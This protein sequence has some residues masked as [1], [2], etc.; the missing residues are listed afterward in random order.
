LTNLAISD[1]D[2]GV[3]KKAILALSSGVRNYQP[4]LD[5]ML[6][7]LPESMKKSSPT[8]ANDMEAM[9]SLM[10]TLRDASSKKQSN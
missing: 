10:Q 8:D 1:A 4:A 9:N 3:R 2:Q 6:K 7:D 5:Q